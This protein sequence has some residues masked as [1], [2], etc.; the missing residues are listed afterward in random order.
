VCEREREREDREKR[1]ISFCL[2]FIII[3]LITFRTQPDNLRNAILKLLNIENTYQVKHTDSFKCTL[4]Q[5]EMP[6]WMRHSAVLD[7]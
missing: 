6:I 7:N 5:E 2:S 1:E 3:H 4:F